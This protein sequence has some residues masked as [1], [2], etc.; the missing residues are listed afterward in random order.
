MPRK[1]HTN[2]KIERAIQFAEE[3]GWTVK[4]PGKSAH[5]FGILRCPHNDKACRC[6]RFCSASIWGTPKNPEAE[7]SKIRRVVENCIYHAE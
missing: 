5:S 7:A 3:N 6:G 1:K 4:A 2:Q